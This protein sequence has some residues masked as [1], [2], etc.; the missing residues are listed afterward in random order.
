[1]NKQNEEMNE[2]SKNNTKSIRNL[3]HRN[4]KPIIDNKSSL[5][6][7]ETSNT[8]NK[9]SPITSTDNIYQLSPECDERTRSIINKYTHENVENE[10]TLSS[11]KNQQNYTSNGA[12]SP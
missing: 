4:I 11:F 6:Y 9:I 3:K 8:N 5:N 7:N 10:K 12:N 1:M 2:I